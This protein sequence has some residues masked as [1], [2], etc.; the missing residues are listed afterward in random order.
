MSNRS[1]KIF[2]ALSIVIPFLLYCAYYYGMMIKNAPYKFSEFESLT[3]NYGTGDSLINQYNSKTTYFQYLD[4]RDSLI[5]TKVKLNK[6][7]LIHL[8]RRAASLGFWDFPS[9][10]VNTE[11][12][13]APRYVIELSYERK[14]K[15]VLIDMGYNGNPKLKDAARR[16]IQEINVT[17][18]NAQD[19]MPK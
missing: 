5:K 13:N 14:S 10:I 16:L 19:R 1:K 15:R 7:D 8:H 4:D 11:K 18:N 9:E 12:S 2:L 3:F 6:A 17:L